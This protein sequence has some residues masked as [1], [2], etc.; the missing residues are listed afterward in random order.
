MSKTFYF[1][2]LLFDDSSDHL[3]SVSS[4]GKKLGITTDAYQVVATPKGIEKPTERDSRIV[5]SLLDRSELGSG[6]K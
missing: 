4:T 6:E 2:Y 1:S 5:E 3:D